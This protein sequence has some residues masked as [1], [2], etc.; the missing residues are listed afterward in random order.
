MKRRL[1]KPLMMMGGCTQGTLEKFMWVYFGVDY[2]LVK[3]YV[4]SSC[5]FAVG[6]TLVRHYQKAG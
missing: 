1:G 3:G 2:M 4:L 5:T 6:W